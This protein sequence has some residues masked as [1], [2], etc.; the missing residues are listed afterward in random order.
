MPPITI[1]PAWFSG[2]SVALETRAWNERIEALLKTTPSIIELGAAT[3]REMRG[4]GE[5]ILADQPH[6]AMARWETARALGLEVPVR[7]FHPGGDLRG[8]YL[9]VHG[10][11]HV[12]GGADGQ[13]QGLAA[14]ARMLRVGVVSVEYRLAPENPWPAPADDCEAAAV[15]LAEGGA[16]DLFGVAPQDGGRMII[17]GESAGGHL[18]AVTMI[19]LKDR[20][21]LT[22]F[23]G[24]NLV[25]GIFDIGG[26]PSVK[27]WGDR[28]LII[29]GPIMAWFAEQLLPPA[30]WAG[31]DLREPDL[32]PL[33]ADLSGLPPALLTCGTLDPLIDDTLFMAAAMVRQGSAAELSIWPGG[34]HAFNALPDLPIAGQAN[35]RML[36]WMDGVLG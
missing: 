25:Y 17:G 28:N 24:A 21:G 18:A 9:H 10:G 15:W 26:T 3:V 31:R 20:H 30:Q 34:I 23:V 6:D 5:G 16:K 4:A 32:S 33:Y 12:I 7:V 1:D 35:A 22:P 29:S 13:D 2:D 11:G 8:V 14:T 19:R 27:R 36:G